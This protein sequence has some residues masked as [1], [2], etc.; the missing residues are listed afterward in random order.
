[1]HKMMCRAT[2]RTFDHVRLNL[3][4]QQ[5]CRKDDTQIVGKNGFECAMQMLRLAA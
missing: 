4:R 2:T 5:R 1:M 3:R